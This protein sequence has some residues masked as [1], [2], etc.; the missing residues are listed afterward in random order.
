MRCAA[1]LR[2]SGLAVA[3]GEVA[4]RAGRAVVHAEVIDER[5]VKLDDGRVAL[6]SAL[7]CEIGS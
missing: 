4:E 6:A 5:L 1:S 2:A 7:G 3:L